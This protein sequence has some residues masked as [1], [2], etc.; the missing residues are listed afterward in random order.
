M[1]G[2]RSCMRFGVGKFTGSAW[3]EA[4]FQLGWGDVGVP[5]GRRVI[6]SGPL[7][8]CSRS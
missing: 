4:I 6:V 7:V 8:N 2:L 1:V 5:A 3:P